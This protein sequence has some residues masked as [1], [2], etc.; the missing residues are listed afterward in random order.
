VHRDSWPRFEAQRPAFTPEQ[1]QGG[2][3]EKLQAVGQVEIPDHDTENPHP[4]IV[5]F[6]RS[7]KDPAQ[8]RS[9]N[10]RSGSSPGSSY[11]SRTT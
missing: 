4:L 8:S 5:Y 2:D 10:R 11:T 6:Y 9:T 3:V 7:L 1:R